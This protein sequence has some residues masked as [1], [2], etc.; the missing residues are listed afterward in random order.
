MRPAV[1]DDL[2]GIVKLLDQSFAPSALESSLVRRLIA[3]GARICHWVLEKEA[4]VIAYVCYSRAYRAEQPIGWHLAPVAV[5]PKW[6]KRGHGSN[7]IRQSLA[8]APVSESPVFVLGDPAYYRRFGFC[9][10]REPRCP[11]EPSNEHFMALR[12]NC[13]DSFMIGYEKEF[14]GGEQDGPAN[15]SQPIR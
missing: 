15:G 5:H 8:Q 3:G 2:G 1:S 13:H 11:F 10:A 9:L 4:G 6:Q 14:G 12:Y 7:L